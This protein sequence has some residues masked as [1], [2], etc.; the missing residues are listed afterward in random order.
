MFYDEGDFD[1]CWSKDV[2][3][4]NC[5]LNWMLMKFFVCEWRSQGVLGRARVINCSHSPYIKPSLF[6]KPCMATG[7]NSSFWALLTDCR[8]ALAILLCTSFKKQIK[9]MWKY[10]QRTLMIV[11]LNNKSPVSPQKTSKSICWYE[12][13]FSPVTESDQLPLPN[14]ILGKMAVKWILPV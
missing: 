10:F 2:L 8:W 4:R 14:M 11:V 12:C 9:I 3:Y 1:A 5:I 7:P 6:M 13:Y